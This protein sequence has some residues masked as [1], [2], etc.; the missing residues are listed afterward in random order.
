MPDP[1]TVIQASYANCRPL[2]AQKEELTVMLDYYILNMFRTDP[3]RVPECPVGQLTLS[4]IDKSHHGVAE[5]RRWLSPGESQIIPN[6]IDK[7]LE[8]YNI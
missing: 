2:E 5:M 1:D 4:L 3:M 8:S 6:E 7:V